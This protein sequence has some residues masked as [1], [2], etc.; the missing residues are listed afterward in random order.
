MDTTMPM[1]TKTTSPALMLHL[2][3]NASISELGNRYISSLAVGWSPVD[4]TLARPDKVSKTDIEV[5]GKVDLPPDVRL[6]GA[7]GYGLPIKA[8]IDFD[9]DVAH[10]ALPP[11]YS[12]PVID[13]LSHGLAARL[14]CVGRQVSSSIG[15]RAE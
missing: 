4:T 3:S 8:I 13:K 15:G 11:E 2:R 12:H 5:S 14:R 1:N 6:H 10:G 7:N 9:D